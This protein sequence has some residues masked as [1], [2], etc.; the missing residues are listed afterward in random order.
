[1]SIADGPLQTKPLA[2]GALRPVKPP[3]WL[4]IVA[5]VEATLLL[6]ACSEERP[7]LLVDSLLVKPELALSSREPASLL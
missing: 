7:V 1:M 2:K 6:E 4:R 3:L 5:R